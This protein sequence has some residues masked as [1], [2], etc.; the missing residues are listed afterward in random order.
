MVRR[1]YPHLVEVR[2]MNRHPNAQTSRPIL[3]GGENRSGT[4]LLSVLLDS[5]PD[6]VVGPP[7]RTPT[8][9]KMRSASKD[10]PDMVE[11][12]GDGQPRRG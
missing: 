12:A 7:R 9:G 5:H 3:M 10:A 11:S 1:Q 4:T 8:V 2:D 6:A